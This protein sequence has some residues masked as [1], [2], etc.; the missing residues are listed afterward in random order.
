M[1]LSVFPPL[2]TGTAYV[3]FHCRCCG[4]TQ[5]RVY[6][7]RTVGQHITYWR[8]GWSVSL[9]SEALCRACG[10]PG[11]YAVVKGRV[12]ARHCDQA[13]QQAKGPLCRCECGGVNHGA[14][15]SV[16]AR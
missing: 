16:T 2:L 13:C 10:I 1:A 14:A 15:H 11:R 6:L 9:R 4:G 7:T 5:R 8:D 12:S 3:L